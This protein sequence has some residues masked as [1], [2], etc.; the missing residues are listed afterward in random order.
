MI[1]H[2]KLMKPYDVYPLYSI[3]PVRGSDVYVYDKEGK[4]YLDFYGGHAVISVG[5]SHP[6]YVRRITEQLSSMGFYSNSIINSLQQDLCDKLALVSGVRG[7]D[8]FLINSGAEAN[9]NALKLASFYRKGKKFIALEK[10]FHGRTSAAVN[11][12]HSGGKYQ[13]PINH[14]IDVS[15]YSVDDVEGIVKAIEAGDVTGVIIEAIQGVGGLDMMNAAGLKAIE[16]ACRRQDTILILDEVQCGYG[17]SGEFFAFQHADID[18]DIITIAK[19][20]GNGFPV[21]GVLVKTEKMPAVHGQLGTTFGGNHLAC[22]AAIAVL[23]II[24]KENLITNAEVRGQELSELLLRVP[25]VRRV[26]GRGLM[27][28][29]EFDMPVAALRKKLVMD[30]QLFTG[31]AGDPHVLRLLPPLTISADH[32]SILEERLMKAVGEIGLW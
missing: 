15:Y 16:A 4:E 7:Y 31:S 32:I 13:A 21:G 9:D 12:T 10:S 26:K 5:H 3:E 8:L 18:P 29:P 11:V 30:H 24:Q 2:G 20:M 28:G 17:R 6:E 14:G 25:G 23:D 22:A 1:E 27:I 19:G